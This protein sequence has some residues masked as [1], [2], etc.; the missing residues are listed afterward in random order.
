MEAILS[1]TDLHRALGSSLKATKVRLTSGAARELSSVVS[2]AANTLKKDPS[3]LRSSRF[4]PDIPEQAALTAERNF[5]RLLREAQRIARKR[6]RIDARARGSTTR[7]GVRP[8]LH[9]ED[10]R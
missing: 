1:K 7:P 5:S 6:S 4:E 8:L 9:A 3:A 10:I 2:I